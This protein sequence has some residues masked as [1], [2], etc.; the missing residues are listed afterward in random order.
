MLSGDG[1]D[2]DNHFARQHLLI[3]FF[4]IGIKEKVYFIEI[5]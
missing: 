1:F 3:T 4:L 5:L 2:G